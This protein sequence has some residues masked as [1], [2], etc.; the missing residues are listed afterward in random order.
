MDRKTIEKELIHKMI[1]L[2]CNAKHPGKGLCRECGKLE[3][4][5]MTKIERCPLGDAKTSCSK[6]R[7]HCYKEPEQSRIREVMKYS[8]P[9]IAFRAP[10]LMF[11]Y[12]Y[13]KN[14]K[15]RRGCLYE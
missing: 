15:K 11:K 12:L 4:Y 13:V 9:K 10:V 6:C 2:Y 14:R 7:I 3:A 5:A 1:L 8:G